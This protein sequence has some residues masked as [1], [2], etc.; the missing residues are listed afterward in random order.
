MALVAQVRDL[1]VEYFA[2]LRETNIAMELCDFACADAALERVHAIAEQ[3]RQPTQRW[4][5]G[6]IAA[7]WC[8]HGELGGRGAARRTGARKSGRRRATGRRD[9]LRSHARREPHVPG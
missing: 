1:H 9:G 6:F 5:V 2:T 3:T 7:A 8:T 4:N